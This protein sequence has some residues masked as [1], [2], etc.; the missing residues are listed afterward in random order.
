MDIP[1]HEIE[2]RGAHGASLTAPRIL[3]LWPWFE[4]YDCIS[5]LNA[6]PTV[7]DEAASFLMQHE[8]HTGSLGLL[9]A[10]NEEINPRLQCGIPTPDTFWA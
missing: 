2:T 1:S 9:F 8:I 6:G 7:A 10:G 4:F 5:G 3:N